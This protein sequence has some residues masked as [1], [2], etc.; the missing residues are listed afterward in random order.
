M[1]YDITRPLEGYLPGWP[2]DTPF[3]FEFVSTIA[4]GS[5]CNVGAMTV[6]TH[7]GT[8]V[9]APSHYIDGAPSMHELGVDAFVGL[10]AIVEGCGREL[11]TVDLFEGI[12]FSTV[13]RVL[14]RTGTWPKGAPFPTCIPL[15][16]DDVPDFLGQNGVKLIGLDVPSVDQIKSTSLPI[17]LGLGRNRVLILESIDLAGVP[18]GKYELIALPLR[19]VGADGSP[20]RAILRDLPVPIPEGNRMLGQ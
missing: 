18:P 9:D 6:S 8:H 13:S 12:D 5:S 10:A 20:V 17:H 7:F 14:I 11:I 16:A 1:I 19:I 4:G 2:G 15:L 3:V